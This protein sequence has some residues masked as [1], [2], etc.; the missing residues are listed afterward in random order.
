MWYVGVSVNSESFKR[1]LGLLK[2]GSGWISS[3][4]GV[5]PY[6]N[7]MAVSVN[8]GGPFYGWPHDRARLT[9]WCLY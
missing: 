5:D 8:W 3:R 2:R 7:Y 4:F 6:K 9:S 1:S